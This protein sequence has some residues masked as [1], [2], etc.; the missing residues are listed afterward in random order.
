MTLKTLNLKT[1][2]DWKQWGVDLA[3]E[4]RSPE[5]AASVADREMALSWDIKI[6]GYDLLCLCYD[7]AVAMG[8]H[9]ERHTTDES[10]FPGAFLSREDEETFAEIEAAYLNTVGK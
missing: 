8:V 7:L 10:Y 3:A 4:G 9:P 1:V 6:D 2:S 5:S